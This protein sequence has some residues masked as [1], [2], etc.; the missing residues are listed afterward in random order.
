MSYSNSF[1]F[2]L[3][4]FNYGL[5]LFFLLLSIKFCFT[6]N[7]IFNSEWNKV[8]IAKIVQPEFNLSQ[9]ENL[10]IAEIIND[11]SK[12]DNETQILYNKIA[13]EIH[14]IPNVNLLD[15]EKTDLILKEHKLQS[16]GLVEE[17]YTTPFG[18]FFSSGII[19]TGRI[20]N[21]SYKKELNSFK[22]LNGK[23]KKYKK[24]I[25]SL[26]FSI[27]FID[28]ATTQIVYS[29][30]IDAKFAIETKP[31]YSTPANVDENEVFLGCVN[32]LA[33]KFKNLFV[34]HEVEYK[35]KFQKNSKFNSDLKSVCALVQVEEFD[36]AYEK[37][38]SILTNKKV[39]KNDKALS[40]AYYNIALLA[41][42]IDK[43]SDAK[44]YSKLGY[45]KNPS[46][47]ECLTL[48]KVLQ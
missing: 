32:M 6:Q 26:S 40:N 10:I 5:A 34:S 45:L 42:Y 16:S 17:D 44:K 11:R 1:K 8:T 9:Y 48:I 20:V 13:G 47:D 15:R 33:Q 29:K 41:L 19:M 24:G 27:Q 30:T 4:K 7:D 2:S 37:L 36:L 21:S 46:N 23:N 14:Q 25:Q 43:Y 22:A 35:I 18:K 28:L 3:Q 12:K 31:D 38:N 39:I